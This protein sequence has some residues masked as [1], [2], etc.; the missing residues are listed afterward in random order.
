M[1]RLLNAEGEGAADLVI[2]V[3]RSDMP[4]QEQQ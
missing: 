4:V 1:L 2:E 3:N